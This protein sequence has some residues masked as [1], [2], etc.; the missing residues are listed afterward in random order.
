MEHKMGK[1]ALK[2]NHPDF[3]LSFYDSATHTQTHITTW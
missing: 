2:A 1:F 3:Y